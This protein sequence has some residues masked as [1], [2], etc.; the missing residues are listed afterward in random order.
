MQ[1]RLVQDEAGPWVVGQRVRVVL[2]E[3][4]QGRIGL[5]GAEEIPNLSWQW[6]QLT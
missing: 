2:S 3:R 4:G 5:G 1:Q 6:G